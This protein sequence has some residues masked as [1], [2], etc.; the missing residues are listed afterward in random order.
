MNTRSV[1]SILK[2]LRKRHRGQHLLFKTRVDALGFIGT[3]A[4]LAGLCT[5]EVAGV[6]GTT[7]YLTGTGYLK[8]LGD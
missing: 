7:H 1:K 4:L 3:T 2:D 5:E 8:A 6:R